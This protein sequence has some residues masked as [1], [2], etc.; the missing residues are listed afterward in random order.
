MHFSFKTYRSGSHPNP[1]KNRTIGLMTEDGP[2]V[3]EY[4]FPVSMHIGAPAKPI[5]E[6][7]QIVKK[8]QK[9]A[10]AEG[11]ISANIHSSISGEVIAI[12]KRPT[13]NGSADC[14][15]IKNDYK[16]TVEEDEALN[17]LSFI[18]KI[19][20]A[21]IVG[22]GGATFPTNVKFEPPKQNRIDTLILNG[23]ECEPY[24]TADT[25][26]MIEFSEEIMEGVRLILDEM[27]SIKNVYI[28]IESH[29][30]EAIIQMKSASEKMDNVHVRT[31]K[32]Q[33]PQGAEKV[34]IKNLTGREVPSSKLPAEV[35]C[36][37]LNVVTVRAIYNAIVHKLPSIE[38]IVTVSGNGI[39]DPKNLL[40]KIGTPVKALLE[41]CHF[42]E[43]NTQKILNG[44]PM[45][46]KTMTDLNVPITKG[47]NGLLALVSDDLKEQEQT[48]CIM[49]S[50][51]LNVCPVNLQPILISETAVK[52]LFDYSSQLGAMDCIECGNCTYI[53]PAK[54]PLL[55]NIRHAKTNIKANSSK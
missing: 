13:L 29:S 5:V 51:C 17:Q 14:I 3:D 49:C 30:R 8:G 9:I 37:V 18:E 34:L 21:G 55:E 28:G 11:K 31:L 39:N 4:I 2:L 50:E 32:T 41:A 42:D 22:M 27:P 10:E 52:G 7:G 33:Y 35:G 47:T 23:S 12:E 38:R 1:N 15:V 44:G 19:S 25:R 46:G 16:E 48:A 20:A 26:A 43:D 53:C 6:V 24:I 40:V 54:I 36:L 45:M